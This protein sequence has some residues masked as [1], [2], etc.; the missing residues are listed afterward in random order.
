MTPL[1]LITA[2]VGGLMS[3]YVNVCA[4]RFVS[5]ALLVTLQKLNSGM[6][7]FAGVL[8]KTGG[9]FDGAELPSGSSM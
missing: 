3:E 4:G 9:V 8:T 5:V 1:E 2:F 6:F 7:T